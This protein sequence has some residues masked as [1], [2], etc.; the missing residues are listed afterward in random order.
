MAVLEGETARQFTENLRR[1]EERRA[2]QILAQRKLEA[3]E[4]GKEQ[5]DYDKISSLI[6]VD[7]YVSGATLE[8]RKANLEYNY[9]VVKSDIM[10]IQEF[11]KHIELIN[12]WAE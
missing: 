12:Q 8:E 3:L 5:F 10:T 1:E 7:R 9:Y 6:Y 11:I 2:I 4:N